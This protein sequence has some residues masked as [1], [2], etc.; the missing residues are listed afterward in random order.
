MVGNKTGA[1]LRVLGVLVV[2]L[3]TKGTIKTVDSLAL[4]D[5]FLARRGRGSETEADGIG[6]MAG[7]G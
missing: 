3:R 2:V 1:G 4:C 5:L 7:L 6:A